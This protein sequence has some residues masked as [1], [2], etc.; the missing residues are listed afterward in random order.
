MEAGV[1]PMKICRRIPASL[2]GLAAACL[3]SG[4]TGIRDDIPDYRMFRGAATFSK[5]TPAIQQ[6]PFVTYCPPPA[7]GTVDYRLRQFPERTEQARESLQLISQE[8]NIAVLARHGEGHRPT[9]L[10]GIDAA[11][12]R[13]GRVV[14]VF[15]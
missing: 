3:L 15:G 7:V 10:P 5:L 4:C 8:R 11:D 2:A 12:M 9:G 13:Q 6:S 1:L 14:S